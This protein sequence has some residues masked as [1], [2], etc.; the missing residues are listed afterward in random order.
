MTVP[1]WIIIVGTIIIPLIICLPSYWI[2]WQNRKKRDIDER[3]D[4]SDDAL[5]LYDRMKVKAEE[6]EEELENLR[7]SSKDVTELQNTIA[8]LKNIVKEMR[9]EIE[10]LA[11][12]LE[13]AISIGWM[14]HDQLVENKIEPTIKPKAR[15]RSDKK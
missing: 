10:T 14:L 11:T 5:E 6:V 2:L 7:A 8:E 13:E 4:L 15:R 1:L 12:S 3:R 9:K